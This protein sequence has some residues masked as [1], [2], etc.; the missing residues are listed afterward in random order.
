MRIVRIELRRVRIPLKR[1]FEH[2]AAARDSAERIYVSIENDRGD[3]GLGEIMP[4]P[5]LTGES[6]DEVFSDTAPARATAL[7]GRSFDDQAALVDH[8]ETA[9]AEAGRRLALAGGFEAALISL[10]ERTFGGF[11]YGVLL[12]PKRSTPV[13]RCVTI[14]LVDD[15][16][17]LRRY[18]LEAKMARATLVKAKIGG[19]ADVERIGRLKTLLGATPLRLDAN[20][21][22]SFEA[23]DEILT[24]LDQAKAAPASIEQPLDAADPDLAGKLQALFERHGVPIMA[25]ESVCSAADVDAWGRCGG[26]RIV[27]VRV[28][29]C[30]GLIGAQAAIEAARRHRM[31]IVGGTLVG[32]SGVLDRY[33]G[34][35][36]KRTGDMP[37][38]EGLGQPRWLLEG[39]PT[40]DV[41]ASGHDFDYEHHSRFCLNINQL[42]RWQVGDAAVFA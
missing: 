11:D 21:G 22:L 14:G 25:D 34:I 26:Y 38:M 16:K 5:Y 17:T 1:R 7:I 42:K 37:Y 6:F 4:R 41:S 32:E 35:L 24:R 8:L 31:D 10:A 40:T 29:K 19:V 39:D 13:G 9:L 33:G 28:G 23:A 27:N 36:L 18:A 20:G 15:E 3:A 2:A 12:G 30:G